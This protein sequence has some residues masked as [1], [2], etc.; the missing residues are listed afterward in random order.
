[1]FPFVFCLMVKEVALPNA[2]Y[3]STGKMLISF[4]FYIFLR[5][6]VVIW[7]TDAVSQSCLFYSFTALVPD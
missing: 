5:H 7:M 1:M 4:N 3:S 2:M 6:A